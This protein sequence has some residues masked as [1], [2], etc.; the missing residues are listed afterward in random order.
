MIDKFMSFGQPEAAKAYLDTFA[1]A[2]DQRVQQAEMMNHLHQAL[3]RVDDDFRSILV[4]RDINEMDYQ[5]I[6]EVLSVPVGTVKSRL[7]RARLA[8]REE[9][10]KVFPIET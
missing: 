6:S 8:L 10:A 5:Q 2:A 1:S 3:N 7:F 9:M 4:L